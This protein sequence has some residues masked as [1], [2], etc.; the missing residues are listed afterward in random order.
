MDQKQKS[1]EIPV[2]T[3]FTMQRTFRLHADRN[4]IEHVKIL[5]ACGQQ[6]TVQ[7]SDRKGKVPLHP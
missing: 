4:E 1:T 3:Q 7:R 6:M 2:L 5:T